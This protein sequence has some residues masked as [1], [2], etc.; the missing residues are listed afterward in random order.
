MKYLVMYFDE[1]YVFVISVWFF[2]ICIIICIKKRYF[3]VIKFIIYICC[4]VVY[5]KGL[6]RVFIGIIWF[7]SIFCCCDNFVFGMY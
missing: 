2:D 3:M 5:G 6:L 1:E 7:I 4:C